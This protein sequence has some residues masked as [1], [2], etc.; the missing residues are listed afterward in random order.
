[1]LARSSG[2]TPEVNRMQV[3]KHASESDQNGLWNPGQTS[4]V[5]QN[6]GTTGATKLNAVLHEILTMEKDAN[7]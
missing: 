2:V 4:Q 7:I 6:R 5:V 1:M 3:T